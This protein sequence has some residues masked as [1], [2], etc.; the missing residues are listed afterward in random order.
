MGLTDRI[1]DAFDRVEAS[2]EL[3]ENT[4]RFLRERR[5]GVRPRGTVLRAALA[6]A[7]LLLLTA[8]VWAH[9]LLHIPVSYVSIDVNPSVEL[10]LN[11]LDR[12]VS[13]QAYNDDGEL[14][15]KGLSLEGKPYT[16]AIDLLL[17]SE[18]MKPYL[19]D[20]S[21]LTFTVA[22]G[23]E[24]KEAALLSGI[25]NSH[26]C[27]RYGGEGWGADLSSL[28]EAH[29]CGLS[30]GKY[31][32][33]LALSQYDETVTP[34]DCHHMTMSEIRGEIQ[35]HQC[36]GSASENGESAGT[37]SGSAAGNGASTESNAGSSSCAAG[38]GNGNGLGGGNCQGN[39]QGS[40]NGQGNGQGNGNG[41]G[42]G[43]GH[44]H[45]RGHGGNHE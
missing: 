38:A 2:P 19:T 31:A 44:G 1:R 39:G 21:A 45:G 15:L 29:R 24:E 13:A 41:R 10:A 3:K 4:L 5:K 43:H 6:C 7:F 22:A 35:R 36:K 26:G 37:A 32:A 33:Y 12:I 20:S 25:E 23:G 42:N 18:A 16:E 28:E 27:R 34:E 9:W 11:R 17:D 30:F 14:V 8:G 40:G